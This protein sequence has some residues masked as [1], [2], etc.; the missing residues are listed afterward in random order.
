MTI[1]RQEH[2]AELRSIAFTVVGLSG[3]ATL[4]LEP[5]VGF[6]AHG[7]DV[8]KSIRLRY[9]PRG[10]DYRNRWR[11][12][13]SRPGRVRDHQPGLSDQGARFALRRALRYEDASPWLLGE[14]GLLGRK[15][16]HLDEVLAASAKHI[17]LQL[18]GQNTDVALVRLGESFGCRI[19]LPVVTVTAFG[20]GEPDNLTFRPIDHQ[21]LLALPRFWEMPT[22]L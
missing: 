19:L 17:S 8:P 5:S 16:R 4:G 10:V 22:G 20:R 21:E 12:V 11:V 18:D 3:T 14:T 6:V 13:E 7:R 2:E 9:V 15:A 1:N